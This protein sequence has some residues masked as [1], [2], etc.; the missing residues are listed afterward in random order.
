MVT[1]LCLSLQRAIF[2]AMR[3]Q[4]LAEFL[5]HERFVIG[6]VANVHFCNRVTFE[7][8]QVGADA[9]EEPAMAGII[10]DDHPLGRIDTVEQRPTAPCTKKV[11]IGI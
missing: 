4:I 5:H 1:V 6:P 7:D 3:S 8:D 11:G 10:T 2:H 9:V